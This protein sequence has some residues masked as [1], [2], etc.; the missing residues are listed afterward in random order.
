MPAPH[1]FVFVSAVTLYVPYIVPGSGVWL[2]PGA[3]APATPASAARRT[4]EPGTSGRTDDTRIAPHYVY[5][6]P[7]AN[8][9]GDCAFPHCRPLF[10]N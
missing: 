4:A 6:S 2:H 7:R 8:F 5:G 10:G 3:E 1:E 9:P